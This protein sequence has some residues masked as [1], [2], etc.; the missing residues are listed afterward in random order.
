MENKDKE[1]T[2]DPFATACIELGEKH[3]K[4]NS[5]NKGIVKSNS[6]KICFCCE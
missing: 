2:F 6:K 4:A 1:M 5:V 3:M